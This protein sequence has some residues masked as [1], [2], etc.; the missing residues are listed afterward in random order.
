MPGINQSEQEQEGELLRPK[1]E[2]SKTADLN[3]DDILKL[4]QL[5]TVL[6]LL[7]AFSSLSNIATS[8]PAAKQ[9]Q[10]SSYSKDSV[11]EANSDDL[12]WRLETLPCIEQR[13][14]NRCACVASVRVHT[15][16]VC[17]CRSDYAVARRRCLPPYVKS[18]PVCDGPNVD[19]VCHCG[20]E[21]CTVIRTPLHWRK[22]AGQVAPALPWSWPNKV[23]A[24]V[25]DG[26]RC[27]GESKG[28]TIFLLRSCIFSVV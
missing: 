20:G 18:P 19:T 8:T 4:V 23:S 26:K 5:Q 28:K 6:L 17:I 11:D 13:T 21:Q 12:P 2:T 7:M 3:E 27:K 10:L 15:S 14:L 24:S 9:H 1:I 16:I 22:A 25:S